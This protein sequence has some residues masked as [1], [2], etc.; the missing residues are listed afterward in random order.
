LKQEDNGSGSPNQS[1]FASLGAE[2]A[3]SLRWRT[4]G[5]CN[6]NFQLSSFREIFFYY[7][8]EF[9]LFSPLSWNYSSSFSESPAAAAACSSSA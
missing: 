3:G 1:F 5:C 8:F 4:C 9:L 7:S 6:P 2:D